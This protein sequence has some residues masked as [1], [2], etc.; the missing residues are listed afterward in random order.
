MRAE[1]VV[2]EDVKLVMTRDEFGYSEV[3]DTLD[4]ATFVRIVTYNI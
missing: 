2:N 3:L 1:I 4:D